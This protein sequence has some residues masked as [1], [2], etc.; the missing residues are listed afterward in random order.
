MF[1]VKSYVFYDMLYVKYKSTIL[2]L[3]LLGLRIKSQQWLFRQEVTIRFFEQ[4]RLASL[5]RIG[6]KLH[7]QLYPE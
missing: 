7:P 2:F 5:G 3:C 1:L 4:L 6:S